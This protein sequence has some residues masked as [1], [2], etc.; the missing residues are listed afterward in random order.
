VNWDSYAGYVLPQ[1]GRSVV[2]SVSLRWREPVARCAAHENSFSSPWDGIAYDRPDILV[3]TGSDIVCLN[4]LPEY[5]VWWEIYPN[6]SHY[7]ASKVSPG[8]LL[9]ATVISDSST[10]SFTMKIANLTTHWVN[11]RKQRWSTTPIGAEAQF[12]MEAPH[13]QLTNFGQAHFTDVKA[14][15]QIIGTFRADRVSMVRHGVTRAVTSPLANK[16]AF[17]VGWRHG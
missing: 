8:D 9:E 10:K 16:Q 5:S 12:F 15:G 17:T 6:P 11:Q 1:R 2:T 14:N 7:Y 13:G 4:G 3:Q